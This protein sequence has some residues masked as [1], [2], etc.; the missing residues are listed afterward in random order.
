MFPKHIFLPRTLIIMIHCRLPF[1][2]SVKVSSHFFF[3]LLFFALSSRWVII[4]ISNTNTG[5]RVLLLIRKQSL[6]SCKCWEEDKHMIGAVEDYWMAGTLCP[7]PVPYVTTFTITAATTT[8]RPAAECRDPRGHQSQRQCCCGSG[9]EGVSPL[10]AGARTVP[11]L[12]QVTY[13]KTNLLLNKCVNVLVPKFAAGLS[14]DSQL[15]Q[16]ENSSCIFYLFL[17]FYFFSICRSIWK[18][19]PLKCCRRKHDS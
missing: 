3:Y 19:L 2:I 4:V 12:L 8:T 13:H 9:R 16:Q 10:W 5:I 14:D 17:F 18:T 6:I 1:I 7:Q 15:L 11:L